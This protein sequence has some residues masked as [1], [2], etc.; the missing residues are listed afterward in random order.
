[1]KIGRYTV[2]PIVFASF[3]LDGGCMFGSVPKNLWSKAIQADTENCI[4]L[5][6]R[7]LVVEDG[8]RT[9]L[10]DVGIG[11]KWS[12]KQRAIYGISLVP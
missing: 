1:M 6:C 10:V 5:V 12:D 9:F 8:S 7:C 11:N 2:T 3:R 4:P